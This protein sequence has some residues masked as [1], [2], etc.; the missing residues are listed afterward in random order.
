MGNELSLPR[1]ESSS[2]SFLAEAIRT[3][4]ANVEAYYGAEYN[5]TQRSTISGYLAEVEPSLF[6]QLY[7]HILRTKLYGARLP[8][9]EHLDEALGKAREARREGLG[10]LN[11]YRAYLPESTEGIVPPEEAAATMAAILDKLAGKANA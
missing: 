3:F 2:P 4:L 9:I 5:A 11:P 7:A 6:D 8:L 1:I 10:V